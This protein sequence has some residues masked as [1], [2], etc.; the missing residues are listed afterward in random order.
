MAKYTAPEG[1][2]LDPQYTNSSP[3]KLHSRSQRDICQ[4]FLNYMA[5]DSSYSEKARRYR[6]VPAWAPPCTVSTPAAHG[7]G[8]R[9]PSTHAE[10]LCLA[11]CAT[12]KHSQPTCTA[13]WWGGTT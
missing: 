9:G 7:G 13:S 11:R 1:R 3:V 5:R 6:P 10:S 8:A 12:A 2:F 4:Y